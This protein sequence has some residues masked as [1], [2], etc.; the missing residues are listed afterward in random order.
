MRVVSAVRAARRARSPD[1]DGRIRPNLHGKAKTHMSISFACQCGQR[2]KAKD[3]HAGRTSKFQK[4]QAAVRVPNAID[5]QGKSGN[6]STSPTQSG[7][8]ERSVDSRH[9]TWIWL[10][11]GATTCVIL[12]VVASIAFVI[13]I[14]KNRLGGFSQPVAQVPG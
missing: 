1:I 12:I 4:C 8:A 3:G 9:P 7:S 2:I 14:N 6:T 5:S 10:A 11:A 13:W